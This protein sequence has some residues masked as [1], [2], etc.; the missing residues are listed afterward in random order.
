MKKIYFL[1]IAMCAAPLMA[2]DF[3]DENGFEYNIL[4]DE[5]VEFASVGDNKYSIDEL[6]IPATVENEGHTYTVV[7]IADDA[8]SMCGMS[9]LVVPETVT[10]IGDGA[11]SY[12]WSLYEV[13]LST[14]TE[15]IGDEAFANCT[16]LTDFELPAHVQHIGQMAFYNDYSIE[17]PLTFATGVEIGD[18]AF[19]GVSS[20]EV[21][22]EGEP[23]AVGDEALALEYLTTVTVYMTTPPAFNPA[24]VFVSD[25]LADVQLIVPAGCA[26]SY[27]DDELWSVFGDISEMEGTPTH[28]SQISTVAQTAIYSIDGKRQEQLAQGMNILVGN[29][30]QLV[31]IK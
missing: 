28:I 3:A 24:D 22:F 7:A 23:S 20:E 9:S 19:S 1:A 27:W 10:H 26:D 31:I 14:A 12:C 4:D 18:E 2:Q 16:M 21:V 30:P 6:E 25:M 17:S 15:W 29:K 11:F 5:C 13:T 8:A